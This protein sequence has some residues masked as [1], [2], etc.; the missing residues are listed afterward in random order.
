MPGNLVESERIRRSAG[1]GGLSDG[2]CAQNIIGREMPMPRLGE[3][4]PRPIRGQTKRFQRFSSRSCRPE[5][6]CGSMPDAST[7]A[8]IVSS[9]SD[10]SIAAFAGLSHP[11]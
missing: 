10:D 4:P 7:R 5:R 1:S 9:V 2:K 11:A 8:E 3:S 6:G